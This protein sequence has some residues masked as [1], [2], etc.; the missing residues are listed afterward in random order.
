MQKCT[1]M[2]REAHV[3]W[4]GWA[5]I[6]RGVICWWQTWIQR[7][8]QPTNPQ[9]L[10]AGY[11][12]AARGCAPTSD[13][14]SPVSW[15]FALFMALS[16]SRRSSSRSERLMY[17]AGAPR[18]NTKPKTSPAMLNCVSGSLKS[19]SMAL[20]FWL[21]RGCIAGANL[22]VT[23]RC[24]FAAVGLALC[25]VKARCCPSEAAIVWTGSE[26]QQDRTNLA[27]Q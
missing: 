3:A 13:M 5:Q 24:K 18:P 22:L 4:H 14:Y 8:K 12:T 20:T 11:Q 23:I 1:C 2:C 10:Q 7:E 19:S 9:V 6:C 15:K 25:T 17:H 21:I 27:G 26:K 16:S